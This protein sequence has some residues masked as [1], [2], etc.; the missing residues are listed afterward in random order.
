MERSYQSQICPCTECSMHSFFLKS[1]DTRNTFELCEYRKVLCSFLP[2]IRLEEK[3]WVNWKTAQSVFLYMQVSLP[4]FP[5]LLSCIGKDTNGV[6]LVLSFALCYEPS[7]L[8]ARECHCSSQVGEAFNSREKS[9][10]NDQI[11]KDAYCIR[12]SMPHLHSS[13]ARRES[14]CNCYYVCH[15][16]I[17]SIKCIQWI[18]T[19]EK[20]AH[21]NRCISGQRRKREREM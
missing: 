5:P 16:C 9:D 12:W 4:L 19:S 18:K 13:L 1:T 3:K 6:W 17:A 15:A 10:L 8:M 11:S 7:I 20:C 21:K 14:Q 2:L